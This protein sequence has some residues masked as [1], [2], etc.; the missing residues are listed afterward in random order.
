MVRDELLR[1]ARAGIAIRAAFIRVR[2][3]WDLLSWLTRIVLIAGAVLGYFLCAAYWS[4]LSAG[5]PLEWWLMLTFIS[6]VTTICA[7]IFESERSEVAFD[8]L[9]SSI[10]THMGW[11]AAV[12]SAI[13]N[14]AL[15]MGPI[16]GGLYGD[17]GMSR[18][19]FFSFLAV[20]VGWAMFAVFRLQPDLGTHPMRQGERVA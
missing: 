6:T 16:G 4:R 14:P 15:M 9:R 3:V 10:M 8:L 5:A 13:H 1:K 11:L 19:T 12:A 20:G 7:A 17:G 2:V 18:L